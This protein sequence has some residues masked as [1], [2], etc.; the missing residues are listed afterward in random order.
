MLCGGQ[1]TIRAWVILALI[2]FAVAAYLIVRWH[3]REQ[4]RKEQLLQ[5]ALH[6]ISGAKPL[7][8]DQP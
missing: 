5:D 8:K 2:A 7:T 3:D 4:R 1:V 6:K